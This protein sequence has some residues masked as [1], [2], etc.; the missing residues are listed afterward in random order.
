MQIR[1]KQSAER[2][3][4]VLYFIV[5]LMQT[6]V[7][8]LQDCHGM[9]GN[10]IGRI[11]RYAEHRNAVFLC[12]VQIHIV[13]AGAA[14]ENQ[15]DSV[16]MKLLHHRPGYIVVYK[17]AHSVV[18]FRQTCRLRS[19]IGAE[20]LD[21]RIVGSLSFIFHQLAEK[22]SVV[23]L[24]AEKGNFQDIGCSSFVETLV[25][26]LLNCLSCLGLILAFNLNGQNISFARMQ[27]QQFQN[28]L[29]GSLLL[30]C[31]HGDSAL[32]IRAAL[33]QQGAGTG[34]NASRI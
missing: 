20:I 4:I 11:S 22:D 21:F 32:E 7:S 27:R 23:I 26:H 14:Q 1:A 5:S 24:R 19:Q 6:A 34:M 31:A 15:A 9:L 28:I 18:T 2:K 17:H 30:I 8:L 33:C 29:R 10:R 16:L 12:R 3:V 25:Q 13:E